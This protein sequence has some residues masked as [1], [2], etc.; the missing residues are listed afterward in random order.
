MRGLKCT[1]LFN[2]VGLP[3]GKLFYVFTWHLIIVCYSLMPFLYSNSSIRSF[4]RSLVMFALPP[5]DLQAFIDCLKFTS[6]MY[7]RIYPSIH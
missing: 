2:H 7:V 4:V 5:L 6:C 1:H 3:S